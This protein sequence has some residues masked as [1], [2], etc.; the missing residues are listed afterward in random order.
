[1]NTQP[2]SPCGPPWA[3]E[4]LLGPLWA[5][6]GPCGPGPYGPPLGPHGPGPYGPG[7]KGPGIYIYIYI[8]ETT[9]SLS[10][11]LRFPQGSYGNLPGTALGCYVWSP[12]GPRNTTPSLKRDPLGFWDLPGDPPRPSGNARG[13]PKGHLGDLWDTP[14]PPPGPL[15]TFPGP[16]HG[17][18]GAPRRPPGPRRT[19][20]G[21][22]PPPPQKIHKSITIQNISI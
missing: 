9:R 6:L 14:G 19:L 5:P 3:L 22:S 4:G 7:P 10:R 18:P 8:L 12:K 17:P 20:P 16:P 11:A 15:Q 21:P 13:P 1:M 2:H